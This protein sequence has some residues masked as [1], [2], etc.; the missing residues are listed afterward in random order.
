VL[1]NDKGREEEIYKVGG[2]ELRNLIK[3]RD[4]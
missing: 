3:E 1:I 4:Q 2:E